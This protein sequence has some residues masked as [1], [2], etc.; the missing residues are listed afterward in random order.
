M[1]DEQ[2]SETIKVKVGQIW[3]EIKRDRFVKVN[4]VGTLWI[5]ARTTQKEDGLW[6]YAPKSLS[7]HQRRANFLKNFQLHQDVL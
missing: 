6:H 2:M 3:K 7:S 1:V 4:H 5:T